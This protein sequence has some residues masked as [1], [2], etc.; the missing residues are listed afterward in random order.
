MEGT[1]TLISVVLVIWGILEI[2][3][4]FKIWGMTNDVEKLKNK[5]IE[6]QSKDKDVYGN[7]LVGAL[8]RDVRNL[9]YLGKKDEAFDLLN[10]YLY[11]KLV[12]MVD[13]YSIYR[14]KENNR[15]YIHINENKT[16]VD[17]YVDTLMNSVKHLYE[18]IGMEIPELINNFDIDKYF[19]FS[20]SKKDV[21]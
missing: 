8:R 14:D 12:N 16:Y 9:Y 7:M 15:T 2:I 4:F 11:Y 1:I 17:D 3:L 6:G 21:E 5:L 10:K 19:D 18:N 13:T 20:N